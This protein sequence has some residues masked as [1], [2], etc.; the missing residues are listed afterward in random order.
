MKA[1]ELIFELMKI[2]TFNEFDGEVVV[3]SLRE[4]SDLWT[5]AIFGRFDGY[6][7]LITLR[8]L[9]DY[10]NADTLYVLVPTGKEK[11]MKTLANTWSADEID[12]EDSNT[13]GSKLGT[14]HPNASL[15]RVWWD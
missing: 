6:S 1:Q 11:A 12:Y 10:Y 3:K 14:S 2:A 15:L 5:G 7:E 4:N 8:D 13:A 9:P